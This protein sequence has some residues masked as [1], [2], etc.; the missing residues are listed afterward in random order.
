MKPILDSPAWHALNSGNKNLS[1]GDDRARYFDREVS[2]FAAMLE[3]D[4]AHFRLLYDMLPGE[5]P[6]LFMTPVELDIP[7]PWKVAV[8]V[9]ALQMTCDKPVKADNSSPELVPLA[10][11]HVP[12]MLDLTKLTNPGPFSSKTIE[13]GHYS[14][15]FE[16]NQLVA[17][18][19]QR[20]HA[21]NNAEIS[22]VCTHPDHTGKGYARHLLMHQV[23]RIREASEI[24][25]LHVRAD[26]E[27]AI[28]VYE[29]LGF[30]KSRDMYFYVL[31]KQA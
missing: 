20:L 10:Y 31:K 30:A 19:G 22:A 2:P 9:K 14:G 8:C 7:Q 25:Y 11:E 24:P 12:Q 15:I 29:S 18:A 17:M 21:Y 3:N 26:N 6:A 4:K 28:K 27:R 23:N 13:F 1:F 16:N 5:G